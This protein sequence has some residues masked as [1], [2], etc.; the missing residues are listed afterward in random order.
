[1]SEKKKKKK[2]SNSSKKKKRETLRDDLATE[3]VADAMVVYQ[4]QL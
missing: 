2:K 3:R 1:V 4:A